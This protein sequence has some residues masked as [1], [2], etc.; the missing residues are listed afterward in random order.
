VARRALLVGLDQYPDPRN[1]LNSCVAD[2]LAFRDLLHG[3]GFDDSNIRLLHNSNAT[4]A[5]VRSG[6]DWL[7]AGASADDRLVF[8][9]SSHGYRYPQ[10]GTMREVICLYDAFLEDQELSSRTQMLPQ[11]MLTVILDA[12]H[13]GGMDKMFF[14]G[15]APMVAR[16]KVFQPDPIRAQRDA[17]AITQ[18]TS[19]KSFGR[20]AT[21]DAAAV[22]KDFTALPAT[23]N[24]LPAAKDIHEGEVELNGVLLA[25][26]LAD[27][28]A[29]AGSPP[30][31]NL[32]AF[33]YGLTGSISQTPGVS[34]NQLIDDATQRLAA[35]R[36]HQTPR[37]AVPTD[38]PQ[39]A[40]EAFINLQGAA[41]EPSS[42]WLDSFTDQIQA[43]LGG[44]G[45]TMSQT[46]L[47]QAFS[48]F[49]QQ[50]REALG[51]SWG[52]PDVGGLMMDMFDQ[53]TLAGAFLSGVQ[54]AGKDPRFGA[55]ISKAPSII[56]ISDPSQLQ[57]KDFWSSVLSTVQTV[58]PLIFDAMSKDFTEPGQA[59][60]KAL[61]KLPE[62]RA[63]TRV[64]D[65]GWVDFIIDTVTTLGPP[66]YQAI[67][68]QKDFRTATADAPYLK[69]PPGKE[70]D[71]NWITDAISVATD[72][73]PYA[74]PVIAAL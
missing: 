16:A 49:G 8:F 4:L 25:A 43:A 42:S 10:D 23:T 14:P 64:Q 44:K 63:Q 52:L 61:N 29:A 39:L 74:W 51:K 65:K 26:C 62:G 69:I 20:A 6:L 66:L 34:N 56:T 50:L 37:I 15:D 30:T 31:N 45:F 27:Q 38:Q 5:N 17:Q 2:T 54:V 32:S 18:V 46:S 9:D 71:K 21:S 55:K 35:L 28:T 48:A 57:N 13:S 19:F 58:A 60:Q 3:Y 11:G 22:V 53:T 68:G 47:D 24:V 73:L 70:N 72:I 12:C 7:V 1:N 41:P 40:D 33:T 36:M 67:T 59:A